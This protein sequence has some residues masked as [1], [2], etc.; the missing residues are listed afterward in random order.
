MEN[1]KKYLWDNA[2]AIFCWS[3]AGAILAL[4]ITMNQLSILN[5]NI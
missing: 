5:L 3:V 4:I 2:G 1:L